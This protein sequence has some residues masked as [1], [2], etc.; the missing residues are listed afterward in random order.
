MAAGFKTPVSNAKSKLE[1][2]SPL[3]GTLNLVLWEFEIEMPVV[4]IGEPTYPIRLWILK[5]YTIK[6]TLTADQMQFNF[7]PAVHEGLLT[8]LLVDSRGGREGLSRK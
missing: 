8:I 5:P 7:R 4:F 2:S 1:T 3:I 6:G